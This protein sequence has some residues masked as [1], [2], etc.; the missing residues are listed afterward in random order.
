MENVTIDA[1][2]IQPGG[3]NQLLFETERQGIMLRC[4]GCYAYKVIIICFLH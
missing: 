3:V 1:A 4:E 2:A